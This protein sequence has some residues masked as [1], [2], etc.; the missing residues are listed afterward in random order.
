M[1]ERTWSFEMVG[2]ECLTHVNGVL[3][4][5]DW[6]KLYYDREKFME[7][8]W[9]ARKKAD[10]DAYLE[11]YRQKNNILE[12]TELIEGVEA[13]VTTQGPNNDV[14]SICV[15]PLDKPSIKTSRSYGK[16]GRSQRWNVEMYDVSMERAGW[17]RPYATLRN[18]VGGAVAFKT[19]Q[20]AVAAA[21]RHNKLHAP[22]ARAD[23]GETTK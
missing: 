15:G 2:G 1:T 10:E 14:C 16:G 6:S 21:I 22:L 23:S 12:H 7:P 20:A 4:E 13:I 8:V 17:G 11:E 9:A 18:K 19:A 3:T 5:G